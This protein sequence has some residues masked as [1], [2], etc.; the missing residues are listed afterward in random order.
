MGQGQGQGGIQ[1]VG[2]E[3]VFVLENCQCCCPAMCNVESTL[4][5]DFLL[6]SQVLIGWTGQVKAPQAV[7][8]LVLLLP[9]LLLMLLAAPVFPCAQGLASTC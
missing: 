3:L 4:V 8:W 7:V 6:P 2:P 9:E 1:G 5:S